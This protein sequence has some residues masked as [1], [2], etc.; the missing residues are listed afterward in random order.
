MET[1]P[2]DFIFAHHGSIIMVTPNTDAATEWVDEHLSL[3]DWQ[4]MG[5][6]FAVEHRYAGDLAD[7]IRADGLVIS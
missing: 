6:A 4:W 3:E 2:A 5:A 7:G 1:N